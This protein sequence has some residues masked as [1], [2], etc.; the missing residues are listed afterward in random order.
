LKLDGVCL[1]TNTGGRYLGDPLLDPL[2]AELDRRRAV[3]FIHP[4]EP[5]ASPQARLS[6]PPALVEYIFDTARAAA[7]LLLSGCLER[8]PNVSFIL[9]HAGGAVPSQAWRLTVGLEV[10]EMS[11]GDKGVH[12]AERVTHKYDRD[13]LDE[14]KRRLGLLRTRFF[15]DLALS[16]T[17]FAL[18]GLQALAGPDRILFG[19][20][21]PFAP[22]FIVAETVRRLATHG[23]FDEAGRRAVARDNAL[24]LFP[25]LAARMSH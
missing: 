7:N 21:I 16:A 8:Y 23:R 13:V 14:G 9:S 25:G 3:V 17:P 11:L 15:Y 4:H 5:P 24:K 22:E 6:L 20:D 10:K 1:L 19:S 2:M 18:A 12:A